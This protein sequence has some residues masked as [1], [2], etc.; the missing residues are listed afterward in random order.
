MFYFVYTQLFT[1]KRNIFLELS[2]AS[3]IVIKSSVVIIMVNSFWKP[4]DV[5]LV[6]YRQCCASAFGDWLML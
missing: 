1:L 6:L 3:G 5:F 2:R 4:L